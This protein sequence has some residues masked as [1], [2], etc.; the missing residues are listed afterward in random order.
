MK[1]DK[2]KQELKG[3]VK[4]VYVESSQYRV[5][6]DGQTI[7]MPGY[8]P[9]TIFNRD[10]WIIEQ[11]HQNPDGSN[12]R[13]VN[14]YSEKGKLITTR[15]YNNSD[16]PIGEVKYIYDDKG[17][18]TAEQYKDQ[19]GKITTSTTYIYDSEG[20]KL[21]IQELSFIED[22]GVIVGMEGTNSGIG[23]SGRISRSETRY[24]DRGEEIEL[25]IFNIDGALVGRMEVVRDDNGN[26][27][28][29]THY[30]G[31]IVEFSPFAPNSKAAK[32]IAALTK[33]QRAEAERKSARMFSPGSVTSKR[34]HKYDESGRLIETKQ[35]M[36]G[37]ETERQTFA[38]D[39]D[40]N[41]SE[42]VNYYG[43]GLFKSKTIFTRDFDANGNWT[44]E[45]V[46]TLSSSNGE[47]ELTNAVS[48]TRRTITYY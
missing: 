26:L 12:W 39:E 22:A 17:R 13:I 33:E 8:S 29:V 25:K 40:G 27:I 5:Q 7:E 15:S 14:D 4:T 10:D 37:M 2:E 31:D 32:K 38:Y 9:T 24:N 1:T 48:L 28:E 11:F 23:Y 45:A 30:H 18:L 21:K 36:M 47:T 41:K 16:V 34:I 20:R 42:Q 3:L 35:T 44:K 46:S 19:D 6:E 43:N